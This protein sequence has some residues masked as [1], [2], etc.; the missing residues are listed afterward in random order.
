MAT[1]PKDPL[2]ART[3]FF[4]RVGAIAQGLILGFLVVLAAME[5]LS[6]AAGISPFKYQGF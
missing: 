5:L 6:L 3:L 1:D 4:F 2:S